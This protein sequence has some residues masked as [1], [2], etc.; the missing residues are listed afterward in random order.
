ME[1]AVRAGADA[2]YFGLQG[3]NARARATNFDA[4]ELGRTLAWLHEHGLRVTLN[5]HPADGVRRHEDAYRA[6][7]EALG[8]D[9]QAGDPVA[10]DVTDEAFLTAYLDV[11]HRGL[12]AEGVDFWWVDWQQGAH[13]RLAGVDPLWML[14][15]AHFLDNAR[16]GRRPR[17]GYWTNLGHHCTFP[18]KDRSGPAG[19][20]QRIVS[21]PPST[22]QDWPLTHAA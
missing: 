8:L 10:F 7:C 4:E 12:E 21:W 11:L 2:V 6:M 22:F 17:I 5:V 3:F 9:P 13:S 16:D 15:I 20:G 19:V 14:N 18:G 1:A